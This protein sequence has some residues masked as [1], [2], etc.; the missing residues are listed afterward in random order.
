L[1]SDVS[2]DIQ[3]HDARLTCKGIPWLPKNTQTRIMIIIQLSMF[4]YVNREV[5]YWLLERWKDD[6]MEQYRKEDS[7]AV[8][9]L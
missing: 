5:I 1:L 8:L 9:D 3:E 7:S 6:R 2:E 4:I